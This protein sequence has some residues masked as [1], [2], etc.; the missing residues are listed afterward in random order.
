MRSLV[1]AGGRRLRLCLSG[2]RSAK[3]VTGRG[4]REATPFAG[5]DGSLGPA[6]TAWSWEGG[7]AGDSEVCEARLLKRLPSLLVTLP[8]VIR[9]TSDELDG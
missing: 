4:A 5:G 9:E 3:R 2:G 1:V 7:G 8:R 6:M